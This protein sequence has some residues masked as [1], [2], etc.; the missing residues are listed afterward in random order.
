MVENKRKIIKRISSIIVACASALILC[1][2]PFLP[3]IQ[4]QTIIA[5]ADSVSN[6][7]SFTGSNLFV[8]FCKFVGKPS[9]TTS[10]NFVSS[11][12]ISNLTT[13]SVTINSC[14]VNMSG[15]GSATFGEVADVSSNDWY[16]IYQYFPGYA[17]GELSP[18]AFLKGS[19][20]DANVIGVTISQSSGTGFGNGA[21]TGN[22]G[23]TILHYFGNGENNWFNIA[24]LNFSNIFN[25][26]SW[27]SSRTYYF[28][29]ENEDSAQYQMGYSAGLKDGE[30][31]GYEDGYS[32]AEKQVYNEAYSAG[33]S[34]GVNG[35]NEYSF[36]H[37]ISAVIDAPVQA[38]MGLFNFELLGVNLAGFFTGLLTVAFIITI[39]RMI[40]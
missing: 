25:S 36:F 40:L 16:L 37:L 4:P 8:N 21:I 31:L 23:I 33:Y 5:N 10:D 19:A 3:K 15:Y 11:I 24:F 20:F 39:V 14:R 28:S 7:Y 26:D 9:E 1:I 22:Y 18:L 17:S 2:S 13:T 12:F 32:R 35:A 6:N 30:L 34:D 27:Y 38:F 29:L